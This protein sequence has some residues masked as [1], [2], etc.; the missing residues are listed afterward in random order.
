[1]YNATHT[2]TTRR[3]TMFKLNQQVCVFCDTVPV[4]SPSPVYIKSMG[5]KWITTTSGVRVPTNGTHKHFTI[6]AV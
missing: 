2:L 4:Y 1:M 5:P 6:K 3:T